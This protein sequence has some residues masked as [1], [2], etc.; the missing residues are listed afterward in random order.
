MFTP[1]NATQIK[2]NLQK[3]YLGENWEFLYPWY[4]ILKQ[5]K[6]KAERASAKKGKNL[7]WLGLDSWLELDS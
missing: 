5:K 2:S 4:I 1:L 6:K 7:S 3:S